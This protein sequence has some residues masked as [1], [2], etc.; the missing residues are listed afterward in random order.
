DQGEI[1]EE[2]PPQKFFR[3]PEAERTRRFLDQI[4]H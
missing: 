3:A 4:L 1:V 2:A